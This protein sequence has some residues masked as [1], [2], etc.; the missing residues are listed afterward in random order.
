MKKDI[1][2]GTAIGDIA[3]S[4]FEINN[5]KTG[6]EFVLLHLSNIFVYFW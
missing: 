1:L 4:R 2:I 3:G 6:K 5:C